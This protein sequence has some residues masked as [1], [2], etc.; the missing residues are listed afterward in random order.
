MQ[1]YKIFQMLY[2]LQ[3][4][5]DNRDYK[6]LKGFHKSLQGLHNDYLLDKKDYKRIARKCICIGKLHE[7][8]MWL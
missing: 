8:Y 4:Y 3:N 7:D 2:W 5:K 6:K 1:D